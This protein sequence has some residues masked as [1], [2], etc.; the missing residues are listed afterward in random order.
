MAWFFIGAWL[1]ME[2]LSKLGVDVWSKEPLQ[3][4]CLVI[5]GLMFMISAFV[6]PQ[7]R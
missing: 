2:G 4:I 3:A 7:L 1:L 5:A 6:W